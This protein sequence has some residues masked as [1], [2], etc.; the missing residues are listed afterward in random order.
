[1]PAFLTDLKRAHDC[2]ALRAGDAGKRVVLFGWVASRRDHGGLV[3]IDLRDRAG[4]TQIAFEP[5]QGAQAFALAG[6]LRNEFCVGVTGVVAERGGKKNPNLATGDIEVKAD[7]LTIFSRAE[8][9][10]FEITD[11]TLAGESVRLKH[12]YLDLRRPALQKNFLVRPVPRPPSPASPTAR[13]WAS[14]ARTNPTCASTSRSSIS[15]SSAARTTAAASASSKPPSRRR[16]PS[17]RAGACP[18]STPPSSRA[19][20]STSSRGLPRASA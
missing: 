19:P 6:E 11:Q 4:I 18:P 2:G 5:D 16:P 14:T 8:T 17:S 3:F 12:R 7:A 1:M 15:R 13:P 9:P 20:I 10:P